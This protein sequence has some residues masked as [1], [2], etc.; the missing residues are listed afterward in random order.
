MMEPVT[1]LGATMGLIFLGFFIFENETPSTLIER[2]PIY[3]DDSW[4]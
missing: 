3:H 2:R 1:M 4:E